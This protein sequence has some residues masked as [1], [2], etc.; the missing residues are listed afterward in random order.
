V[1]AHYGQAYKCRMDSG[2]IRRTVV[3]L[4]AAY[5]VALHGLLLSF[6]PMSAA[7]LTDSLAVLCAYNDTDSAG[8][9]V[10]H[11]MP[12]V[13]VCTAMG[14]GMAGAEPPAVAEIVALELVAAVITPLLQ[15]VAPDVA[16]TGPQMSRG[17]P[18]I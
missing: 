8:Y 11:G 2:R 17:P 7:A 5:A 15:W 14:H 18:A 10:Q 16:L 1:D 12:C 3:A 6:V 4:T 9:P 13:A